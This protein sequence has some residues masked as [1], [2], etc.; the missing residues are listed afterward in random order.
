MCARARWVEEK[1]K[2]MPFVVGIDV[3]IRNMG[4]CVFDFN[5]CR[6]TEWEVISLVPSGGKYLPSQNVRYVC[7]FVDRY[8]HYFTEASAVV[9]ERQMRT[10]MQIVEAVL[11]ALNYRS[12]VVIQ[13]RCV[14]AHYGLSTRNYRQNKI[15]AT[16]FAKAFVQNN[17]SA[18]APGVAERAFC[19]P[20]KKLDDLADALTLVLYYLDTYS[21]QLSNEQEFVITESF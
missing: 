5:T 21:N 15:R 10:N 2:R 19:G 16:N 7:E 14:K 17:P 11:H 3:G 6:V 8:R 1:R 9:I 13:P 12:A 18:F 4:L 20:H